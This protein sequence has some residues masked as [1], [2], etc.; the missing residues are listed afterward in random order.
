VSEVLPA[1]F[2]GSQVNQVT[3]DARSGGSCRCKTTTGFADD[4]ESKSGRA[5]APTR[6]RHRSAPL[7][8]PKIYLGHIPTGWLGTQKTVDH[9]QALIRSGAKDFYVRQKAIDILLEKQVKPKDYL[10]EVKALFEWVQQHIRYTKDTFQ[11]EVLHS[12]RRMLELRAGDCDDMAILLGAM[13]E[14]IGHPVRLAL[15]GPDPLRQ[16]LFTHIY[17]E[18]FHK[19]GWIPL[20]A[21]MP[22]PMGWAPRTSVKKIIAIERRSNMMADD[23][24]LQG[25]SGIGAVPVWLRGLIRAV[26]S[27]A[28]QPKDPRVKSLWDLLRQRQWLHRDLWL[29]AVLHRAWNRGLPA[30][31][32]PRTAS[33]IKQ[34]LRRWGVLPPKAAGAATHRPAVT[35]PVTR[36]NVRAVRPVVLKPV[37]SVRPATMQPVRPVRMQPAGMKAARK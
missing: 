6:Q 32:R 24:E 4:V 18:V 21:T 30:R 14:A 37:A 11:V 19:G 20:D 2:G 22:H 33:R 26:R 23:M 5:Q 29:K 13:L 15:S 35:S 3:N 12:A 7:T 34:T 31:R 36:A 17:L 16:D 1:D 8:A 27:E 10:A 25:I 28:I 9:V